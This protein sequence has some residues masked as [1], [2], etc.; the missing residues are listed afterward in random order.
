MRMAYVVSEM[1]ALAT[2]ITFSHLDTSF[3]AIYYL[4]A[5][6]HCRFVRNIDILAKIIYY[7]KYKVKKLLWFFCASPII[8][9]KCMFLNRGLIRRIIYEGFDDEYSHG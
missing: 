8:I 3:V 9:C 1:N 6:F 5:K 7:C 4:K 2:N